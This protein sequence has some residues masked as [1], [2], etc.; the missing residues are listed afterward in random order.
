MSTIVI[1]DDHPS[2]RLQA[3]ALLEAEGFD[4]VGE[5]VDGRSA[6]ELAGALKPDVV[7]LDIGL[8]DMDGFEVARKLQEDAS[9]SLVLLT[10][11]R[12]A[13]SYG[14]R[15]AGA[16]TLGFLRKDELSGTTIAMAMAMG[17]PR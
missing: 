15:I 5:A 10:S 12:D 9:T 17:R 2:F 16:H 7:L 13:E 14:A 8:P 1:V 4:V 11:S 6:I 3:R